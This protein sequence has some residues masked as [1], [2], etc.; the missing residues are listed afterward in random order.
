MRVTS[1]NN[2]FTILNRRN[3][4]NVNLSTQNPTFSARID[5]DVFENVLI[6]TMNE[7]KKE[8]KM[9]DVTETQLFNLFRAYHTMGILSEL[10]LTPDKNGNLPMHNATL[11][12]MKAVHAVLKDSPEVLAKIHLTKNNNES[13]PMHNIDSLEKLQEIHQALKDQ[14]KVIAKIHLTPLDD[15]YL[16]I[17]HAS[18]EQVKEIHKALKNQP[19]TIAK[20]HMY[21]NRSGYLPINSVLNKHIRNEY[22]NAIT[23]VAL[24]S[25][26]DIETSI[27]LLT[28]YNESGCYTEAIEELIKQL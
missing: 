22:R 20:I 26:L 24:N 18:L 16:F 10:Q 23:E 9:L 13:L 14:P 25:D 11:E 27:K 1:V 19:E 7:S 21:K 17:T 12:Y 15:G 28:T 8:S 6:P 2:Y 4:G 3:K 5:R